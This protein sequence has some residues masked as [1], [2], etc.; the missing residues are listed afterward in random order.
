MA[1]RGFPTDPDYVQSVQ[2][3]RRLHALTVAGKDDDPEADAV[4]ASLEHPWAR[5]SEPERRR[6]AGL[7]EDLYTLSE[8]APAALPMNPEAQRKLVEAFEARQ[9]GRWDEA[10]ELLRR[11]GPH[12]DPALVSYLRGSVWMDAG[13]HATAALFLRHAARLEPANENYARL[14]LTVLAKSD[15]MAAFARAEEVLGAD[16]A[17]AP[18][19]VVRAADVRLLSTRGM[20]DV[21]AR[22]VFQALVRV[23]ERTLARLESHEDRQP[24]AHDSSYAMATALA[25]FCHEHLGDVRAALRYCNL[26]VAADPSNDGLLVARGILRYGADLA[27]VDDF[28]HAVR[29]G[30]PTVWPYFFMAHHYLVSSRFDECRRMCEHALGVPASDVVRGNLYEWLAISRAELGFPPQ[31]VRAAFEEAVRLEPANERIRRNLRAFEESVTRQAAQPRAWDKPPESVV[32]AVGQAE[33]Q[34]ELAAK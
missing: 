7:S 14:Y 3:L 21:D 12:V 26:G 30:S 13:D 8:P 19:L 22:P 25:A 11:W 1:R 31:Q 28:E 18:S 2:G 16:Q 24:A 29:Y 4:R 5:L 34:P 20:S 32:Q 9:A 23:L 17:H 10:L 6:I 15:P 33:F 27:A